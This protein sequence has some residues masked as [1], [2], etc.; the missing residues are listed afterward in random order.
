MDEY[1]KLLDAIVSKYRIKFRSQT[2]ILLD[3]IEVKDRDLFTYNLALASE[4]KL[5]DWVIVNY[6][7]DK[8]KVAL[9]KQLF[10]SIKT[11]QTRSSI[12]DLKGIDLPQSRPS[13]EAYTP[14]VDIETNEKILINSNTKEV[15]KFSYQVWYDALDQ[16]QK[17]LVHIST[18][19]SIFRYDP[20][21]VSNMIMVPYEDYE[22]LKINLYTPPPWRLLP[23]PHDNKCPE[24]IM[25]FLTHLFPKK[26]ALEYALDWLYY[27]MTKRHEAYLVL[28]GAKGIGKGIFSLLARMLVGKA[29]FN[30][31]PKGLLESQFNSSLDKQRIILL[32]EFRVGKEE[33][34]TLKRYINKFQNIEKKGIDAARSTETFNSFI[35]S[36]NDETDMYLEYD[37]RRFSVVD[38]NTKPL[39]EVMSKKAVGKLV[40]RLEEEEEDL[41][42]AWGYFIFNRGAKT[43]EL[44]LYKG[45]KYHRLI[46]TSLKVWQKK[47]LNILLKGD[48]D[49]IEIDKL[50]KR[51]IAQDA[52]VHF[53]SEVQK[54]EDFLKN[55]RYGGDKRLGEVVKIED[56]FCIRVSQDLLT[57]DEELL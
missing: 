38:M 43:D 1:S 52:K 55:Y 42:V 56:D 37:D 47:I 35:V 16:E 4:L 22:L 54:I 19:Y 41:A 26:D 18:R 29:H 28:N 40:K 57:R 31:A 27:A 2:I 21:D 46:Q 14:A 3:G 25:E 49:I 10:N 39:L 7:K 20:Y 8:D 32:D 23:C 48:E 5:G 12:Q 13:L 36:N 24:E 15:S 9:G 51:I 6:N 50:R 34:T 45:E 33:H 17:K 44:A 53:P 30:D 11:L